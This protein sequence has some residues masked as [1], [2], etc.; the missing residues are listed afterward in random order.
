MCS[1][2]GREAVVDTQNQ[3][4]VLEGGIVVAVPRVEDGRV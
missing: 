3:L 1:I 4:L 2:H